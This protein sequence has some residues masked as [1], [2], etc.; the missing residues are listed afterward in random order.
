MATLTLIVLDAEGWGEIVNNN[1]T[2]LNNQIDSLLDA[3]KSVTPAG[4][5]QVANLTDSV[6]APSAITSTAVTSTAVSGTGDDAN[7]NANFT[8]LDAFTTTAIADLQA[9]RNTIIANQT[10]LTNLVAKQ[11]ALLNAIREGSGFAI[12]KA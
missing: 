1:I 9:L 3:S 11:N 6:S 8:A 4:S 7:I 2:I 10:I 5:T 12:L